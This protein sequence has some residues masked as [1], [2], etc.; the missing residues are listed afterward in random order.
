MT[1]MTVRPPAELCEAMKRIN[2]TPVIRTMTS[3]MG[4]STEDAREQIAAFIQWFSCVPSVAPGAVFTMLK[5]PVDDVFHACVLNTAFYRNLC[6]EILGE[7]LDHTPIDTETIEQLD[8]GVRYTV[9][10]LEAT[11]GTDLHP[12]LAD[13]R[14]LLDTGTYV[15]SCAACLSPPDGSN[16]NVIDTVVGRMSEGRKVVH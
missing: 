5:V 8:E 13:W 10:L 11:Y 14:R 3:D 6:S 2:F 9:E 12:A 15:L 1:T 7:F 16:S 4:F